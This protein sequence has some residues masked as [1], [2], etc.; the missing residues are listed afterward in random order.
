MEGF[1]SVFPIS[2]LVIF[3][4]QELVDLLGSAEEDWTYNTLS[5]SIQ[6]NHGY[7]KDS[8]AISRLLCILT[9]FTKV[10]RRSFLQF[11]TGA[12]KL[13][14]GGF[15]ALLPPFTVVRKHAETGFSDDDYL[16]S[17]MT[18]ANYLKLPNY[19]SQEIMKTKLL[20]AMD[21]GAGSFHL[22]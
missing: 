3:S 13:P 6:A 14:V 20:Q 15:N 1:S 2:S 10:Q 5:S 17:V 8:E 22:S 9:N 11:T 16:P 12:P 18:C 7:T 4:P 21:E 19:S